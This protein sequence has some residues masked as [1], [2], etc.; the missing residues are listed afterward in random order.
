MG[1]KEIT[2][3]ALLLLLGAAG[4]RGAAAPVSGGPPPDATVAVGRPDAGPPPRGVDLALLYSSNVQG[5]AGPCDC[6]RPLGGLA[7][8]A[9]VIA[10]ARAEADATLIVDA[11]DLFDQTG[12]LRGLLRHG[13]GLAASL[14]GTPRDLGP[15]ATTPLGKAQLRQREGQSRSDRTARQLAAAVAAGGLDAFT[16]GERDLALGVPV[17]KRLAA[18]GALPILS[19][20]LTDKS[21][22]R[23]FAS[24]RVFR[25]GEVPVGVF[26]VSAPPTPA[27]AA[28]WQAAGI[29][30]APPGP[31]AQAAIAALRQQ[32]AK[33]VVG[34]FHVGGAAETRRLVAGLQ[35]LDW[36]VLGHSALNLET[37]ERAGDARLLEALAE[38]KNLGRLDL[39][40]V[41]GSL[42]FVDAAARPDLE[43]I[44]A[45]H[46]GQLGAYN[47][48][49]GAM[50]PA[51]LEAYYQQRRA[52]LQAAIA[53]ESA[54]LARL[55]RTVTGS[56]F[57]NRIIPLDATIPDD[58]RV[59]GLVQRLGP[60]L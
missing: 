7:R 53:R 17:L 16:P 1:R 2:G 47:R 35:G 32:G 15:P 36:A 11:G 19:S 12:T 43:A 41:G 23:L 9:T 42:A 4:C 48:S 28:R 6:I 54:A 49:L 34:L 30:A 40:V 50:D 27:D 29:Q 39:H 22:A 52:Q 56:W 51:A 37:P 21:G 31:A 10:R 60:H 38:G 57:E 46:R 26:G 20:N 55:P 5:H 58:P 13:R 25:V 14:P 24:E 33:V 3:S 59:S 8:R 45:D 18:V 44:L